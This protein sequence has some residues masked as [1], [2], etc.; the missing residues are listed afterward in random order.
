ML[1]Y[2]LTTLICISAW[3]SLGAESMQ[4]DRYIEQANQFRAKGMAAEA[5]QAYRRAV[6]EARSSNDLL[7]LAKALNNMGALL[8][9]RSRN[10]EALPLY[11]E[12]LS[13]VEKVLGDDN[14]TAVYLSN[15]GEVYRRIGR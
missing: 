1:R 14:T 4:A 12:A 3:V 5:E 13:L 8:Y 10:A 11:Q 9:E 7:S 2:L 6:A 15:L